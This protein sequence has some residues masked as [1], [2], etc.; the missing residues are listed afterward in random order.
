MAEQKLESRN[1][2]C[3]AFQCNVGDP[4]EF[5]DDS[6]NKWITVEITNFKLD[7][8]SNRS[9][10]E[11]ENEVWMLTTDEKLRYPQSVKSERQEMG[12]QIPPLPP[13]S[14]LSNDSNV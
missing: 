8:D 3:L 4:I 10:F 1:Q 14:A 5:Y 7:T 6:K 9:W 2:P 12:P 13:L 11:I